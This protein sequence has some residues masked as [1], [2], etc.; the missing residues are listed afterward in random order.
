MQSWLMRNY[1]AESDNG[2]ERFVVR[3][4]RGQFKTMRLG[5][6]MPVRRLCG[7]HGLKF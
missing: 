4:R 6:T 3:V 5:T 2:K 7:R 1:T